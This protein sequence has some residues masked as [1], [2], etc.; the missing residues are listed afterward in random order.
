MNYIKHLNHWMELVA[1]DDRLTPHH[2][3]LYLALF[4]FWNKSRFPKSIIIHRNEVL[5]V[6]KIGSSKTYYKCLHELHNYGYIKYHPSYNPM[7]GSEVILQDLADQEDDDASNEPEGYPETYVKSSIITHHDKKICECDTS[8]TVIPD[9][10]QPS[11]CS[12]NDTCGNQVV[13]PFYI[14][15]INLRNGKHRKRGAREQFPIIKN[16][17]K[18]ISKGADEKKKD[19]GDYP[20]YPSYSSAASCLERSKRKSSGR[21]F[22]IPSL[23]QVKAFFVSLDAR[24][25][26]PVFKSRKDLELEAVKFFH[27]YEANGWL[28]G[29]RSPMRNWLSAGMSWMAKAPYFNRKA[30]AS[31]KPN[32]LHVDVDQQYG[33]PL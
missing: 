18:K 2:V 16:E 22:S 8:T 14:N 24:E 33:K 17:I 13:T 12:K 31:E 7:K 26:S 32:P 10:N 25:I 9:Q 23:E 21:K 28:I 20:S 29:G 11:F 19:A 27:H 4:Q 3:S 30:Y 1:V 15:N 5:Q 6:S